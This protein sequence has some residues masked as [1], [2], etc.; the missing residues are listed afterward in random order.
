VPN[1][2]AMSFEGE[3]APSFD[4][5]WMP[6]QRQIMAPDLLPPELPDTQHEELTEHAMSFVKRNDS[7]LLDPLLDITATIFRKGF[8]PIDGIL[9]QTEHIQ[10]GAPLR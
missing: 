2:L 4:L 6:W 8:D 1:L 5:A 3:L 9:T 10:V 7:D